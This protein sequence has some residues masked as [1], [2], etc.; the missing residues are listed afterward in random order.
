MLDPLRPM[1]SRLSYVSLFIEAVAYGEKIGDATGFVVSRGGK[2][3]L[4]TNWHVLAGR[5][6]GTGRCLRDDA[7]LPTHVRIFHHG[8]R[9]DEHVRLQVEEPLY[10]ADE[11]DL[12]RWI[13]HAHGREIDL[14]A[15]PIDLRPDSAVVELDL[16]K[17]ERDLI[18]LPGAV[19]IIGY[20]YGMGNDVWPI[21]KTGHIASDPN[22]GY[23]GTTAFLV[24]ATTRPSM[25]GA[26]VFFQ[27]AG[28]FYYSQGKPAV[29][30]Q[31]EVVFLGVYAGRIH[32]KA[33]IGRVW[34]PQ[35]LREM[36][37]NPAVPSVT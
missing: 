16:D 23:K 9:D 6:S 25:S 34:R 2:L 14:A 10:E 29:N 24:D 3:Y 15:L 28:P 32:E 20:P 17:K 30:S 21:W 19:A 7:A 35:A 8:W 36:L 4:V 13:A 5:N 22:V 18:P 11:F 26:P 12:P 31:V 33:E 1:Y 37:D 27:S